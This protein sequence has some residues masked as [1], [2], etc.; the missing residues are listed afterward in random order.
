MMREFGNLKMS[1]CEYLRASVA[2]TSSFSIY[3]LKFII[4][5]PLVPCSIFFMMREFENLKMSQFENLRA[6][7]P[8]GH[9]LLNSAFIIYHLKFE[10][11]LR[12]RICC[13][14]SYKMILKQKRSSL[15]YNKEPE[16][17]ETYALPDR[18]FY[19]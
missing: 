9:L 7:V 13:S 14:H 3:H 18:C 2:F 1:Q 10:S 4:Q 6:S 5:N 15:L 12:N 8:P 11:C 16:Q 19:R 17:Y